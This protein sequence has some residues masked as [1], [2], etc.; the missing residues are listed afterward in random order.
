VHLTEVGRLVLPHA[1]AVLGRVGLAEQEVRALIEHGARSLRIGTF[2]TAG[3]LLLPPAVRELAREGVRVSLVEGELPT[4]VEALRTGGVQIALLYSQP[5]ELLDLGEEF[6]LHPLL[7]DPLLLALPADH[8]LAGLD[9]VPLGRLRDAG[10][11]M[12]AN[13]WDPCDRALSWAC[14]REGFEPVRVMRTDDY[15]MLKGFVAAGTAVAL[16]PR[17]ALT[18]HESEFDLA[19]R[20]IDGP[21]LSRQVSVAM[22]RSTVS[23]AADTLREALARQAE[24]ITE[25]WDRR[26]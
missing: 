1:E 20:P 25:A 9:L 11:I 23:D 3:A 13:D 22:L 17:L 14:A 8:P 12:G 15:G 18:G 6:T 4:V 2:P 7:D 10:W 24:K 16:I 26:P 19:I 5:G 21:P